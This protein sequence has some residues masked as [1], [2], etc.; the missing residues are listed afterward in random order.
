MIETQPLDLRRT[1]ANVTS[2]ADAVLSNVSFWRRLGEEYRAPLILTGTVVF[3]PVGEQFEER[4]T[5]R[6]RVRVW[7]P[8]FSLKLRL[9]F[10]N[11][12]TGEIL[13]SVWLG[14]FI[15][16]GS[17]ARRS[18]LSLLRVPEILAPTFPEILTH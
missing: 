8:R 9:V 18:A 10:I 6:G 5:G 11:G 16:H 2:A 14:P 15:A 7:R 3:K 4:T 12:R 13:D 1:E 17:D